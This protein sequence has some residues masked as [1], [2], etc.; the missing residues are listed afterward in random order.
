MRDI[1][2]LEYKGIPGQKKG[3]MLNELYTRPHAP[4]S[5][6]TS[7]PV[8]SAWGTLL[9]P[10]LE[11]YINMRARDSRRVEFVVCSGRGAPPADIAEERIERGKFIL[12]AVPREHVEVLEEH[13]DNF[14]SVKK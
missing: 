13:R 5:S 12:D 9:R 2:L 14:L 1:S 8:I 3:N 7:M 11:L 6:Y 4:Q 10:Y